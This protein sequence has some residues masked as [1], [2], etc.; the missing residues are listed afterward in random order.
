MN[1]GYY[2]LTSKLFLL[3]AVTENIQV[4]LGSYDRIGLNIPLVRIH[5]CGLSRQ[6]KTFFALAQCLFRSLALRDVLHKGKDERGSPIPVSQPRYIQTSPKL[7]PMFSRIAFFQR[8]LVDDT[9]TE[10][11]KESPIILG[12]FGISK[13]G[14]THAAQFVLPVSQHGAKGWVGKQEVPFE[15]FHSD[16]QRPFLKK[17]LENLF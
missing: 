6:T 9:C 17:V 12:I 4:F 3:M 14:T 16:S 5:L 15:I 11:L 2:L 8:V 10:L 1:G 7:T 13:F